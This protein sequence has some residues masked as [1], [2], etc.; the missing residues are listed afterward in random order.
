[1]HSIIRQRKQYATQIQIFCVISA[2]RFSFFVRCLVYLC[3]YISVSLCLCVSVYLGIVYLLYCVL[4]NRTGTHEFFHSSFDPDNSSYHHLSYLN[5]R[6]NLIP[7]NRDHE[8]PLSYKETMSS[9][10]YCAKRKESFC[11]LQRNT[12]A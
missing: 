8:D 9:L 5:S 10:L 2:N 4:W 1:M 7:P 6:H 3:I 11:L 12:K